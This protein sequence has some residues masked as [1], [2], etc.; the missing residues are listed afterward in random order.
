MKHKITLGVPET[1]EE[2]DQ[3][4][5]RSGACVEDAVDYTIFHCTLGEVREAF[6]DAIT[7]ETG[8]A[9]REIGTGEFTGEGENKTEV[10]KTERPDDFYRRVCAEKGLNPDAEPFAAIATSL[11]VGGNAEVKFDPAVAA[12]TGKPKKLPDDY[13][14]AATKILANGSWDKNRK[15]LGR[16]FDKGGFY[17][18]D[19]GE[20]PTDVEVATNTL[21][22]AIREYTLNKQRAEAE[23]A[24]S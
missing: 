22:W 24:W 6:C 23:K 20:L 2:Y 19:I 15:V 14:N 5:K 18:K 17:G 4:A 7:K 3:L 8:I 13:R 1:L 9:R 12:R 10:T 21:G 11:S 16:A